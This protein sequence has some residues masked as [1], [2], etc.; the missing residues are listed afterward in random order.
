MLPVNVINCEIKTHG[1]ADPKGNNPDYRTET[2]FDIFNH[3]N[4]TQNKPLEIKFTS[5]PLIRTSFFQLQNS[6]AQLT[7]VSLFWQ[8]CYFRVLFVHPR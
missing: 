1:W 3:S 6:L 5:G 7:W 8:I 4:I 2:K